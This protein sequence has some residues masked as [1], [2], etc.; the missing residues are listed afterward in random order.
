[1]NTPA[2]GPPE[3]LRIVEDSACGTGESVP[4]FNCVVI[5]RRDETGR[6]HARVA[7]LANIVVEGTVERDVLLAITRKFKSRIQECLRDNIS[8]P[9]TDPPE[10]ATVGEIER[11]IP[12]HL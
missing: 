11:F 5:L 10:Q 8:I 2:A 1:M 4:V 12:V 7:S 6:I 9:W 3:P